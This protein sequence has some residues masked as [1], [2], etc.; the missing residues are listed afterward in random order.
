VKK[1]DSRSSA[2]AAPDTTRKSSRPIPTLARHVQR[3]REPVEDDP[4]DIAVTS[5]PA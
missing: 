2:R 5:H 1:A 4:P 3:K